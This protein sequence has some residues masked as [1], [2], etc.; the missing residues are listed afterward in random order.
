VFAVVL[1]ASGCT[2]TGG[3]EPQGSITVER[4]S[5]TPSQLYASDSSFVRL[6]IQATNTGSSD[7]EFAV[8]QNGNS[9]LRDSCPDFFKISSF[10]ARTSTTPETQESYSVETGSSVDMDWRLDL[11]DGIRIPLQGYECSFDALLR[12]NYSTSTF[13]QVQLKPSEDVEN[14]PLSSGS[15]SGPMNLVIEPVPG[16]LGAEQPGRY[17]SGADD[18][19]TV[20][21]RLQG[22][23]SDG[24][25][26]VV[27]IE[28]SSFEAST[29]QPLSTDSSGQSIGPSDCSNYPDG[30]R[31]LMLSKGESVDVRCELDIGSVEAS[32]VPQISASVDYTYLKNP[33]ERT[34]RVDNTAT[35]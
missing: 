4:F 35:Q 19:V 21:F 16:T 31:D 13:E 8:G 2:G 7:A 18:T 22:V 3:E 11:R 24:R 12:F 6:Q 10:D 23:R 30:S 28:E 5:A 15:S 25:S 1:L 20:L 29:T 32:R 9:V 27:D 17:V 26:G 14:A 33:G 34:V